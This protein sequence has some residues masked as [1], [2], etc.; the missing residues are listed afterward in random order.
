MPLGLVQFP[1][2]PVGGGEQLAAAAGVV[3]HPEI[4][5]LLGV[6]PALVVLRYRQ[7]CHERRGGRQGVVDAQLLPILHEFLDDVGDTAGSLCLPGGVDQDVDQP[8]RR[9]WGKNLLAETGQTPLVGLPAAT[10]GPGV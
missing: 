5:G 6:G 1:Q 7:V 10:A 4:R 8:V 3:G 2:P 9:L